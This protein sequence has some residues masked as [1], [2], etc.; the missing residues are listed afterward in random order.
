MLLSF[1]SENLVLLEV[2]AKEKTAVIKELVGKIDN[3]VKLV[4]RYNFLNSIIKRQ[5][6]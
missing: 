5:E 2:K 4:N 1:M 6:N 3:A